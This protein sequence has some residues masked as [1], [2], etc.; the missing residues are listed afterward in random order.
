MEHGVAGKLNASQAGAVK[1][2]LSRTL[3]LWQGPPGTG[4]TRTLAHLLAVARGMLPGGS[5][6]ACAA[7]NIAVDNLVAALVA[8]EVKVVRVG[9]PVKV[10]AI[11]HPS[12]PNTPLLSASWPI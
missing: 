12:P 4:K 10:S 8:L 2:A 11:A 9:Q 6:L 7:S 3:T 5:I 1:A